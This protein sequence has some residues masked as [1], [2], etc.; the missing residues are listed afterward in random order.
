MP[1]RRPL[2]RLALQATLALGFAAEAATVTA[3]GAA[4][5]PAHLAAAALII[6][7]VGLAW[8]TRRPS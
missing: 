3:R 1:A 4:P 2:L 6:A 5:I 7:L 8:P